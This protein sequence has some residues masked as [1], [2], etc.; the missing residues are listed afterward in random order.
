[1]NSRVRNYWLTLLVL[2]LA[3][4]ASGCPSKGRASYQDGLRAYDAQ[5]YNKALELFDKALE[6]EPESVMISYGRA[7][8]LYQLQRYEE[9]IEAFET[10][11][12]KSESERGSYQDERKDAAFYRDKCKE[13]LGIEIPQNERA[14][15][16]PPMGE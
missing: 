14:I 5:D 3:C 11:L 1:M 7:L 9:A 15:P 8:S 4:L 6:A 12:Q 13:A 16:P 2:V 10:F